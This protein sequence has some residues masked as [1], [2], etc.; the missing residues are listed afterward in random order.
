MSI[1]VQPPAAPK[2]Q[3]VQR[4]S[5][6]G[7]LAGVIVLFIV[8]ALLSPA[9]LTL[10]NQLNILRQAAFVGIIA[11]GMTF[12]IVAGEI[13]ISVGSLVALSSAIL[14]VL[15]ANEGWP[16]ETAAIAVIAAGAASGLL[17]GFTRILFGVP[18][19]I[20]TLALYLALRGLAQIITGSLPIMIQDPVL[21]F[22]GSGRVAGI[23]VQVIILLFVFAAGYLIA[24]K[25]T[26]GR[27]IYA[28]GG[29]ARAARL[30]GIRV[31]RVRVALFVISGILA[32]FVGILLS[33]RLGSGNANIAGGM[34]FEVIAAVIVGGTSLSG[35]HGSVLGTF[36]G[37]LFITV[38]S[39]ILVLMGV[40]PFAQDVVRGAIVLIA[41][42]IANV[43]SGTA[44]R[45]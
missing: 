27:S 28:I 1:A 42:L 38:L 19:F 30:A 10:I 12:V 11:C 2:R 44:R 33:A 40:D 7:L 3:L 20:S 25:T 22:L 43:Q 31:D 35:G 17:A 32:A 18:S 29:N 5:K 23:P 36:L 14:G 9:F 8:G 26:F 13:D 34:E 41:V 24:K 15:M 45:D 6:T 16:L 21:Q 37:V 39:N 4:L